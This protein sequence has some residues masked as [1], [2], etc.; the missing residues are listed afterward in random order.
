V[1]SADPTINVENLSPAK[2]ICVIKNGVIYP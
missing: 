1:L 2:I